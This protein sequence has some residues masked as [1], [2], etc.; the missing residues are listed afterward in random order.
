MGYDQWFRLFLPVSAN[1]LT[2]FPPRLTTLGYARFLTISK[3]D[4]PVLRNYSVRACRPAGPE[5]DVDFVPH[6]SAADGTA[7][8]GRRPAYWE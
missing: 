1:S 5:I 6:G 7:T 3:T 8:R 4:R 2:R